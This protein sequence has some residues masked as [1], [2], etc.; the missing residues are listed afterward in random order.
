[1]SAIRFVP[2]HDALYALRSSAP[3]AGMV[4][5]KAAE[6]AAAAGPGYDWSSQQGERRPQGRWRAIVFPAT[7]RARLDNARNNTL[8]RLL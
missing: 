3:V 7:W 8:A 2:K 1:M 4:D 6:L 5:A